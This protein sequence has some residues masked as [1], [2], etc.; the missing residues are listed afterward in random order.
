M[1]SSCGCNF[2]LAR[3]TPATGALHSSK[4]ASDNK[5]KDH[6]HEGVGGSHNQITQAACQ[7]S[8]PLASAPIVIMAGPS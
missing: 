2:E 5:R 4:Q 1:Q 6:L 7:R 8:D 3:A